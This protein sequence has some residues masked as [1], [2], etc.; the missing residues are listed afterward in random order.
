VQGTVEFYNDKMVSILKYQPLA[1]ARLEAIDEAL[2]AEFVRWRRG[3]VGITAVNRALATLRRALRLAQ[4]WRLIERVPRIRLLPGERVRDF[5]L[6]RPKEAMYLGACPEPLFSVARFL[7]QTGLRVGELFRLEWEDVHLE[8]AGNAGRGYIHV[9]DGKSKN[10]KRNIPLTEDARQVLLRQRD[11][12]QS[13]FVFVRTDRV[14]P[15][16]RSTVDHQHETVRRTL[17]LPED[18]VIHSFRHT[19]LTRLGEAGAD[20]FTIMKMA[21]HSTVTVSQRYVHPTPETVE[22][23]ID[24]LEAISS[25][26]A[27]KRHVAATISATSAAASASSVQ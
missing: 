22:R 7:L 6:S 1:T 8:P 2:I 20:A 10:A 16:S 26:E 9:R 3:Q 24:R 12:S 15:L 5:V 18:F 23:A 13:R 27:K 21:G 19:M 14:S 11:I 17:G 25:V 4:E